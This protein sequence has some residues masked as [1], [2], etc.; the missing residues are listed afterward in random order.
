MTTWFNKIVLILLLLFYEVFLKFRLLEAEKGK[1]GKS[2][3]KNVCTSR[4]FFAKTIND[5]N[6]A[7]YVQKQRKRQENLRPAKRRAKSDEGKWNFKLT[8]FGL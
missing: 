8:F 6:G 1:L 3:L 7:I 2:W 5:L 4:G